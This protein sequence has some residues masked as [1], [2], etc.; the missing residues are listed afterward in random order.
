MKDVARM[1]QRWTVLLTLLV[2]CLTLPGPLLADPA[3]IAEAKAALDGGDSKKAR[4]IIQSGIE[5]DEMNAELHK[6]LGL[7]YVAEK[8]FIQATEELD[9]FLRHGGEKDAIA[10]A[11][12][13]LEKFGQTK[14]DEWNS[15]RGG[16]DQK[17][18]QI[19]LFSA[20]RCHPDLAKKNKGD[21]NAGIFYWNNAMAEGAN[22]GVIYRLAYFYEVKG[23]IVEASDLYAQLLDY[24]EDASK[25]TC[26]IDRYD[27]LNRSALEKVG[28]AIRKFRDKKDQLL[29]QINNSADLSPEEKNKALD[30]ISVQSEMSDK[31]DAAGSDEER[32]LLIK[33]TG[34]KLKKLA[35]NDKKLPDGVKKILEEE[36]AAEGKNLDDYLKDYGLEGLKD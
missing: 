3:L 17:K 7:I 31:I 9:F 35:G 13:E 23:K 34:E 8:N 16:D 27:A 4:E 10:A 6:E 18:A 2:F 21:I 15:L 24:V 22:A 30:F 25:I 29:E 33:E 20:F 5:A 26:I 28:D 36:A 19:A 12:V 11:T 32:M 14:F 1:S